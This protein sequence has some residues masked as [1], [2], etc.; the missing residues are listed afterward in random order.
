[1]PEVLQVERRQTCGTHHSR[2]M[3]KDGKIPAILY[4]H[5]R[6]NVSLA[7]AAYAVVTD[8]RSIFWALTGAGFAVLALGTTLHVNGVA[9]PGVPMPLRFLTTWVPVFRII[10][11][12]NRLSV[13]ISLSLAVLV[14]L[15]CADLFCRLDQH[16]TQTTS[17][18]RPAT[19]TTLSTGQALPG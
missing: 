8:R 16:R 2:R 3:R 14:G 6:K 18:W 13:M 10:R 19:A 11:Q 12:A 9:Y 1:M 7:V 4:G 15:G 17:R 5:G